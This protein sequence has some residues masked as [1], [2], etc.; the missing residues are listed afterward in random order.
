MIIINKYIKVLKY[1]INKM[2]SFL[3]LFTLICSVSSWKTEKTYCNIVVND[4]LQN[5]YEPVLS[6]EWNYHSLQS[7]MRKNVLSGII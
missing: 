4:L 3:L 6:E 5:T 7:Q 2:Y 1:Y